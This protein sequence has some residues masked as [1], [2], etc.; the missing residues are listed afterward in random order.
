[1]KSFAALAAFAGGAAAYPNGAPFARLPTLG[2]SSWV[3]LGP[4]D[5][6][7]FDYCDERTIKAS[8]DAFVEVGLYDAGYRH[9]HLVRAQRPRSAP[10]AEHEP[11][12]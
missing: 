10:R 6:P 3:A 7:I 12:P 1:M 4:S 5:T 8:A 2:W 11:E 9:F